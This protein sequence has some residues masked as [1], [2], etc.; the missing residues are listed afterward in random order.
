[1]PLAFAVSA[2]CF[3]LALNRSRSRTRHGVGSMSLVMSRKS[4]RAIRSFSSVME[5]AAE[6]D[7][8]AGLESDP[9]AAQPL[10]AAK[11]PIAAPADRN[12]RRDFI[13]LLLSRY[14]HRTGR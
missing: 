5:Q 8:D 13:R 2:S 9:K 6:Q 14:L 4:R 3:T 7:F 11:T 1:M 12:S 10:V